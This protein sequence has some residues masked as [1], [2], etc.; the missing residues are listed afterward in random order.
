MFVWFFFNLLQLIVLRVWSCLFHFKNTT[1]QTNPILHLQ[2][3]LSLSCGHFSIA[4]KASKKSWKLT[5]FT[6]NVRNFSST[7]L[8]QYNHIKEEFLLLAV[9]KTHPPTVQHLAGALSGIK[10]LNYIE[11][12]GTET[13]HGILTCN[14][15]MH[16]YPHLHHRPSNFI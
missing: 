13:V 12:F 4:E 6:L 15:Q 11:L 8:F 16:R 14:P 7:N 5:T 9:L 1:V 10:Q 2:T 3:F